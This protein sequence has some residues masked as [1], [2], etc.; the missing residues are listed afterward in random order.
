MAESG[1]SEITG[2]GGSRG[3]LNEGMATHVILQMLTMPLSSRWLPWQLPDVSA[4]GDAAPADASAGAMA[5]Q[6]KSSITAHAVRSQFCHKRNMGPRL[7]LSEPRF[8]PKSCCTIAGRQAARCTA[9]G[10]GVAWLPV[11][12]QAVIETIATRARPRPYSIAARPWISS[13]NMIS[14]RTLRVPS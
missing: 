9:A 12:P 4:A 5:L 14:L 1:N 10:S 13:S 3:R 2:F 7:R 8:Q 6:L 11:A